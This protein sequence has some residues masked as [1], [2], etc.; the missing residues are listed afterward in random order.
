MITI[1]EGDIAPLL[2]GAIALIVVYF[3][4]DLFVWRKKQKITFYAD[5]IAP[6]TVFILAVIFSYMIRSI[7]DWSYLLPLIM[8]IAF[9]PTSLLL[10]LIKL[11]IVLSRKN[12][13]KT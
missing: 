7:Q 3:T 13:G 6:I 2:I 10:T 8:A 1:Y 12:S 4:I 11:I 5:I 9:V